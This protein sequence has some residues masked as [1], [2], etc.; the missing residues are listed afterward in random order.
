M[1]G[2][3]EVLRWE[4]ALGRVEVLERE[5]VLGREELGTLELEARRVVELEGT[6][7]VADRAAAAG[8]EEAEALGR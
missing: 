5:D 8:R 3:E 6:R 4:D 7:R 1:L 2:R